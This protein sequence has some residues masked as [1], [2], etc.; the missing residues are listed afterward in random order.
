MRKLIV[1]CAL[2]AALGAPVFADWNPLHDSATTGYSPTAP[3][4]VETVW[5]TP[6]DMTPTDY[7][8]VQNGGYYNSNGY[9]YNYGPGYT[10]YHPSGSGAYS[11]GRHTPQPQNSYPS[12]NGKSY[13]QAGYRE[14]TYRQPSVFR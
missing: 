5:H 3:F 7:N 10:P 4:P 2:L 1:T 11:N 13:G 14:P 6:P 8:S 12:N 9:Y